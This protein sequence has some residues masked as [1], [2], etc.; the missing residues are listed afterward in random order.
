MR[1]RALLVSVSQPLDVCGHSRVAEDQSRLRV[2]LFESPTSPG[3]ACATAAPRT[4]SN[5]LLARESKT[6][7]AVST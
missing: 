7:A 6:H 2:D 5:S 1:V 4:E 3:Q